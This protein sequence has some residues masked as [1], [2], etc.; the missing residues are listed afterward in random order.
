MLTLTLQNVESK[1]S[2]ISGFV[3]LKE[4]N[5]KNNMD[6]VPTMHEINFAISTA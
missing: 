6:K 5:K 4:Q 2:G 1:T 3:H